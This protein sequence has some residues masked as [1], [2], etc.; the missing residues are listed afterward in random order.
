MTG[1]LSFVV[2]LG[3]L[4]LGGLGH[5]SS[6]TAPASRSAFRTGRS[7]GSRSSY[8]SKRKCVTRAAWASGAP[9]R[10]DTW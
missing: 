4:W 2:T 1:P 6:E 5:T 7:G 10:R 9:P 8:I 3:L